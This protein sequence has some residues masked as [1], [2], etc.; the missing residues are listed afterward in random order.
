[1]ITICFGDVRKNT[2]RP[3]LSELQAANGDDLGDLRAVL[4]SVAAETGVQVADASHLDQF[5]ETLKSLD[6]ELEAVFR[7]SNG[8]VGVECQG[9]FLAYGGPYETLELIEYFPFDRSMQEALVSAGYR[10]T[11]YDENNLPRL[12]EGGRV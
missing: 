1:M 5:A 2:L 9:K 11:L 10:G 8:W 12:S 3:P 6:H 7:A 4:D